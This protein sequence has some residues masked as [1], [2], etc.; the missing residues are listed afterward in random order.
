M[1][2][3]SVAERV[4]I[5]E[6]EINRKTGDVWVKRIVTGHDCGLVVNP[7]SLHHAVEGGT[8]YGQSRAPT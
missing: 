4:S 3:R 8:L 7:E 1:L 5:A 2:K 6:V